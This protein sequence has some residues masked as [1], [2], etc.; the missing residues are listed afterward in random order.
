M[1]ETEAHRS[2]VARVLRVDREAWDEVL[3]A[4]FDRVEETAGELMRLIALQ[5]CFG[6][7]FPDALPLDIDE[8][9]RPCRACGV[10]SART[11]YRR[12]LGSA[13][14]SYT[15]AVCADC[16]HAMLLGGAA[17]SEV[18]RSPAYYR[19]QGIDGVGYPA[20]ES[21]REYR[22]GKGER[23]VQWAV[24]SAETPPNTLLEVGSGFGFTRRAAERLGLRTSGVDLNPVAAEAAA[25]LY[26][27]STVTGT[28]AEAIETGALSHAGY[29]VVLY[30]FVLEHLEDPVDELR[31]AADLLAPGGAIVLR[32]PGMD[33][34]E[35]VPFGSYYRSF[36]SDHL[37][38]FTRR[39]LELMLRS[40][41]LH[42]TAYETGCGADLLREIL[43]SDVLRESYA[44]GKGPDVTLCAIR[45]SHANST[46]RS[47]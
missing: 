38:L 30:D 34:L 18:Y 14:A 32:V 4:Y 24:Q 27:M 39:S 26:G 28:L 5:E 29:G 13:S 8:E 33:A 2:L 9:A 1:S 17:G 25:R 43:P 6:A 22:E 44:A 10:S 46:R 11:R 41:G 12:T 31:R 42:I 35:I 45:G 37:H 47:G 15:Y 19:T 23:L 20:Y 7:R 3:A 21:E 36:R 16:G 40:A